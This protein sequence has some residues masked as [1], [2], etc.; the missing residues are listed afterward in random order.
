MARKYDA[1]RRKAAA[2]RT[3]EAILVAAFEL[4]GQGLMDLERLAEKADVSLATVRKYFPN[5]ETL[6]EGCTTWGLEHVSLPEVAAIAAID[7]WEDRLQ[8]AAVAIHSAYGG[9]FGQL[10][11]GYRFA[12]ESPVLA[13]VVAQVEEVV[14]SLAEVVV[15]S[16]S[17]GDD[18][19]ARSVTAAMLSPLTHRAFRLH[20][21]L[22]VEETTSHVISI[23]TSVLLPLQAGSEEMS[24][25][26]R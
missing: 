18:E 13:S 6:Y 8:A 15:G 20:G 10:W 16:A 9:L 23:L 17:F 2:D 14:Q 7:G 25:A 24:M 3:R 11:T 12:D 19:A 5:R 1:S 22:K 4:H 26:D 21:N